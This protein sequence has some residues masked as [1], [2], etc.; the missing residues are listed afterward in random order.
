MELVTQ[1]KCSFADLT[2]FRLSR[3]AGIAKDWRTARGWLPLQDAN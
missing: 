2:P 1:G 3:F